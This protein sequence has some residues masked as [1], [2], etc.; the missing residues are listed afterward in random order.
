MGIT[1]TLLFATVSTLASVVVNADTSSTTTLRGLNHG[2]GHHHHHHHSHHD[3]H[4][5]HGHHSHWGPHCT[6]EPVDGV[7][8]DIVANDADF[9]Q[10]WVDAAASGVD[11]LLKMYAPH[12]HYNMPTPDGKQTVLKG[13]HHGMRA[14]FEQLYDSVDGPLQLELTTEFSALFRE[15][16][17]VLWVGSYNYPQ[18]GMGGRAVCRFHYHCKHG[19][20]WAYGYNLGLEGLEHSGE[21]HH[22]PHCEKGRGHHGFHHALRHHFDA[23]AQTSQWTDEYGQAWQSGDPEAVMAMLHHFKFA[24]A[25]PDGSVVVTDADK[26]TTAHWMALAGGNVHIGATDIIQLSKHVGVV[27]GTWTFGDMS[28]HSLAFLH[29]RCDKGWVGHSG[30]VLAE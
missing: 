9:V 7:H 30:V 2:H 26:D 11:D 23:E 18:M 15:N 16:N 13:G 6:D 21:P 20:L 4:G 29:Y 22:L 8:Y 12:P 3:H 24:M 10:A 28:F 5:H 19:W 25:G 1:K 14:M 17:E 27:H